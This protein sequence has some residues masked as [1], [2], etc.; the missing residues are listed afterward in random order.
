[1]YI[2]SSSDNGRS[3]SPAKKLGSGTR[4]LDACP[5]D[6][7][8]LAVEPNGSIETVWRRD[9]NVYAAAGDGSPEVLLGPG[10]QPW[11]AATSKGSIVVWTVEREGDLL[12]QDPVAGEPQKLGGAARD[13]KFGAIHSQLRR[14]TTSI[15]GC[16]AQP[17]R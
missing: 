16:P 10:Q 12:L 6:G 2:A 14:M 7:G 4:H 3:F 5:M 1:M 13:S 15:D 11:I 9:G 8:M 17:H